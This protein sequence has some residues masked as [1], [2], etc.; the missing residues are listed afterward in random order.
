[1]ISALISI[2]LLSSS[3]QEPP[4]VPDPI[5]TED[6]SPATLS[7]SIKDLGERLDAAES[8]ISAYQSGRSTITATPMY[9]NGVKFTNTT[10]NALTFQDGT[11]QNT[12][13][14]SA[15]TV[16][17]TKTMCVSG[18]I[19]I[20]S[21]TLNNTFLA[22]FSGLDF[23]S[24]AM[25]IEYVYFSTNGITSVE[26]WVNNFQGQAYDQNDFQG[27]AAGP[28]AYSSGFG[29]DRGIFLG[30]GSQNNAYFQDPSTYVSGKIFMQSIS[31]TAL[32][33]I[34]D[35]S[36]QTN[37]G[38]NCGSASRCSQHT[39]FGTK[40]LAAPPTR[41]D[42]CTNSSGTTSTP[43]CKTPMQSGHIIICQAGFR[44]FP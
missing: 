10:G 19:L 5:P 42:F 39:T 25:N 8:A 26:M 16:V 6:K 17:S 37:A 40:G 3:A 2:F 27:G 35:S 9:Q 31:S 7:G 13:P 24:I 22:T 4:K 20:A 15:A 38:P 14:P 43:D 33:G 12:S 32:S 21:I 23:S 29:A 1:M 18:G 11:T 41:L 34:L 30:P 28:T 44:S 36:Y